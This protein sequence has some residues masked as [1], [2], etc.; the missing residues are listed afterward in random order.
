[1]LTCRVGGICSVGRLDFFLKLVECVINI[2]S[3]V[4]LNWISGDLYQ[5]DIW[6]TECMLWRVTTHTHTHTPLFFLLLFQ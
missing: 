6:T 5:Q 4:P 3:I 1:L 2:H